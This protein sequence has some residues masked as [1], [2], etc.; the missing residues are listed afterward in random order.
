MVPH[1][2]VIIW[3]HVLDQVLFRVLEL[4]MKEVARLQV[5]YTNFDIIEAQSKRNEARLTP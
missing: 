2:H 5:C 4:K 1:V 3:M